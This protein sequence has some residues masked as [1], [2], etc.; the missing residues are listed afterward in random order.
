MS[1]NIPPLGA[2]SS[3]GRSRRRRWHWPWTRPPTPRGRARSRSTGAWWW[4]KTRRLLW[5]R[6]Y[7]RIVAH[8]VRAMGLSRPWPDRQT[9]PYPSAHEF[10][11]SANRYTAGIIDLSAVHWC[12]Y[13]C[14]SSMLPWSPACLQLSKVEHEGVKGGGHGKEQLTSRH[15][16]KHHMKMCVAER[17]SV[18]ER[19]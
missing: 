1:L 14:V 4:D 18:G 11:W 13:L 10:D 2:A 15:E 6:D 3:G 17:E 7:W 5:T 19:S 9:L 16:K 8:M 12:L